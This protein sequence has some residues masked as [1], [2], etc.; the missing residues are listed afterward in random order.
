MTAYSTE[1]LGEQE[2]LVCVV[3]FLQPG[4]SRRHGRGV[5]PSV[6]VLVAG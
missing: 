2:K 6:L 1:V 4:R 5:Y 3:L